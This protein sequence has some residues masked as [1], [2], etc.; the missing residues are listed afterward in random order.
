M[1]HKTPKPD[2]AGKGSPRQRRR[3]HESQES[4]Y[5]Y[6]RCRRVVL[7]KRVHTTNKGALF[8]SVYLRY[9]KKAAA[10]L[11]YHYLFGGWCGW[12]CPFMRPCFRNKRRS[13]NESVRGRS[14][15][16]CCFSG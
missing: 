15:R 4:S 13:G 5:Y 7:M 2:I 16:T 14:C 11:G 10:Q 3:S 8:S 6:T 9:A 12:L 1:P